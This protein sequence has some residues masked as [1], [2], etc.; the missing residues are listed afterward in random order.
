MLDS[1]QKGDVNGSQNSPLLLDWLGRAPHVWHPSVRAVAPV[2]LGRP[3]QSDLLVF[4]HLC[5]PSLSA[6]ISD[7]PNMEGGRVGVVY[8]QQQ[9]GRVP[10]GSQ[11]APNLVCRLRSKRSCL[12][13]IFFPILLLTLSMFVLFA[14]HLFVSYSP[15]P[16]PLRPRDHLSVS[17]LAL[18]VSIVSL[19]SDVLS[20]G[21]ER[22]KEPLPV[23]CRA[24][25]RQTNANERSRYAPSLSFLT[26]AD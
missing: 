17:Q 7:L 24:P 2:P 22:Q 19:L 1:S 6:A 3:A 15:H 14:Y 5:F 10:V 20:G 12:V 13:P 26:N 11:R 16:P 9:C 25:S 18:R 4:L 23:P 21:M 8:E